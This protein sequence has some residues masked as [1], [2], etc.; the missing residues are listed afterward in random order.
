MAL[1]P[2]YITVDQ[3]VSWLVNKVTF[4]LIDELPEPDTISENDDDSLN[5]IW[6]TRPAN[7]NQ[8]SPIANGSNVTQGSAYGN[9]A[10]V[11]VDPG[12]YGIILTDIQGTFSTSGGV[13]AVSDDPNSIS[14]PLLNSLIAE[15]EA[16]VEY[17]LN[18]LY[19]VPFVCEIEGI[20]T[21]YSTLP[22]TSLAF[23]TN[24]FL[25]RTSIL[26]LSLDFG[27]NDGVRG[28]TYIERMEKRYYS[29]KNL[30]FTR[31]RTGNLLQQPLP[32]LQMNIKNIRFDR[33]P[34]PRVSNDD[35][36]A[37]AF[38]KARINNPSRTPFLMGAWPYGGGRWGGC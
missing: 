2:R 1:A 32:G 26:V 36:S 34:G 5:L 10:G 8:L 7:Y 30:I 24:L 3:A 21:P 12:V 31:A 14:L 33:V 25:V 11:V 13:M 38:A 35:Y 17:D 16:M 20:V 4:D 18:P 28:D 23:L 9:Y 19:N 6:A 22:P 29:M 37:I 15:A 27:K